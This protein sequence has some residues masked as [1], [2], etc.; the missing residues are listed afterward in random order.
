MRTPYKEKHSNLARFYA[1]VESFPTLKGRMPL[2]PDGFAAESFARA[3]APMSSGEKDA[4]LF[5]LG[6]W[7]ATCDWKRYGLTNRYGRGKFDALAAISNW[8][9]RHIAAFIAWAKNPFFM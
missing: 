1:L 4:A 8:D 6:V 5:C 9:D 2:D 7:S 3:A